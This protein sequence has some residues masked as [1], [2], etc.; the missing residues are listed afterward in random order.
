M[1]EL[2]V[3]C[4]CGQ[5]Y[6]FDVEPTNGRMPFVVSCPIC[7]IDGTHLANTQLAQLPPPSM[8]AMP[9]IGTMMPPPLPTPPPIPVPPPVTTQQPRS[10]L[11]VNRTAP[12]A[13]TAAPP[14]LVAA[15]QQSRPGRPMPIGPAPAMP[16]YLQDNVA[17]Q[18]NN[19]MLGVL[20][21]FIG[22]GISIGLFVGSHILFGFN[23]PWITGIMGALIGFGARLMYKGTSS[24]LGGVC[25][26]I[27][28][29]TILGTLY[30]MFGIFSVLLSGFVSLVI[31]VGMAFKIASD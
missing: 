31:G 19:F 24:S 10:G 23:I 29:L 25:A 8:A 4:N 6:K 26:I 13:A 30:F 15:A 27:A 5:K 1:M 11:Q 9:A 2:K 22:A 12:P 3:V 7:G 20:G 17:L 14:A 16:K 21:A 28:F 18:N